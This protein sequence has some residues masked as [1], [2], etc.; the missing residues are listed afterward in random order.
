[1]TN[2]RKPPKE[3]LENLYLKQKMPMHKI[4]AQLNM[5]I[6][7]VYNFLKKYNI[8]TRDQKETFTAKGLQR[9]AEHK[10][11]ISKAQK[12]K[13]LSEKQKAIL[14]EINLLKGIG[15]KKER[16]D[17]YVSIYFPDHPKSSKDGY[18]LEHVLVMECCIGRHLEKEEV[19]HHINEIKDDNRFKN[20]K[21][22]TRGEH[23][24]YHLKKRYKK[25]GD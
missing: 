8:P 18:I 11:K 17:G 9:T 24:S 20:L 25:E 1:M 7:K 21:I 16:K 5:S 2:M 15:H 10:A 3:E 4:A 13:K 12:G 23:A 22:M 14:L 6:G 19:V